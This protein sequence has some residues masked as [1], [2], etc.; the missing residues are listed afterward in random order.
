M[1]DCGEQKQILR[2]CHIDPTASH[3]EVKCTV[4][5]ISERSMWYGMVKDVEQ[6]VFG[7][8]RHLWH[9]KELWICPM[10]ELGRQT[11]DNRVHDGMSTSS[12][13]S[14]WQHEPPCTI[15]DDDCWSTS[16]RE[17]THCCRTHEHAMS[18]RL[19]MIVV[20]SPLL[21]LQHYA[22][23][24]SCSFRVWTKLDAKATF[25]KLSKSRPYS[26]SLQKQEE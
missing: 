12:Y 9:P 15:C 20:Y 17:E 5:H 8:N 21:L 14:L 2:E 23:R 22:M 6:L 13:M 25:S 7:I 24:G 4:W 1:K 11:L 16:G 18:N 19:E 10:L 26:H 3:M